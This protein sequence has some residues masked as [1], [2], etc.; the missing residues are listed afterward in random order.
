MHSYY[1]PP[2]REAT[3]QRSGR[4]LADAR[5]RRKRLAQPVCLCDV[6]S[7]DKMFAM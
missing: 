2:Y 3:W 4:I 7:H 5:Q 1:R 6:T